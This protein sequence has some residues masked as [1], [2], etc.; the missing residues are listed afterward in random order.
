MLRVPLHFIRPCSPVTT[1]K[2]PAGDDWVHEIKLDGYRF[3]IIKAGRQVQ[4]YGRS[5]SEWTRRLPGLTDAFLRLACRSAILDGELVLPD[6]DGAPDFYALHLA[7]R[8]ASEA[9]LAYFAFDLLYR[10]GQDLRHLP[11]T[12]RKRR[13]ERLV[14]RSE[15]PCLRLVTTFDDGVK[16]L[17][18]AERM[19]LE[20]IVSKRRNSAYRS[21]ECRN[22]RKIKTKTWRA[23]NRERW[24]L[25]ERKS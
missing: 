13:L 19:Q 16:L 15:I 18:T 21:G 24:R 17:E 12:E 4:L 2:V 9:E 23:A 10:D 6:A 3:Q 7:V 20:G 11:L 14:H 8:S 5:G 22:W 25:F 1:R